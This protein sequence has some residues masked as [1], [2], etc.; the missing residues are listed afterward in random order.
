VF[1]HKLVHYFQVSFELLSIKLVTMPHGD[2]DMLVFLYETLK[3]HRWTKQHNWVTGEPLSKWD[4]VTMNV[5][6]RIMKLDLEGGRL[7]GVLE[8]SDRWNS[9]VHVETLVLQSNLLRGPIPRSMAYLS[10][11]QV[12]NLSWN[13]LSGPIPEEIYEHCVSLRVLRLDSNKLNGELSPGIANLK[14]LE[15]LNLSHNLLV[16]LIPVCL[17]D[18]MKLE[19]QPAQDLIN[20]QLSEGTLDSGDDIPAQGA[21]EGGRDVER[22]YDDD[23]LLQHGR[24]GLEEALR[25]EEGEEGEGERDWEEVRGGT[26]GGP[27]MPGTQSQHQSRSASP[28]KGAH[29]YGRGDGGA[30]S[31][32][33][34]HS[35]SGHGV[36]LG[37]G[38][39]NK[40]RDLCVCDTLSDDEMEHVE[41]GESD[42][43]GSYSGSESGSEY[44]SSGEEEEQGDAFMTNIVPVDRL[45]VHSAE[46]PAS[47]QSRGQEGGD[48]GQSPFAP[49]ASHHHSHYANIL[50]YLRVVDLKYNKFSC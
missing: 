47:H 44:S 18:H 36:L 7:D 42:S 1:Y 24:M 43:S 28:A 26:A 14:L 50:T 33:S 13:R 22:L 35:S 6:G 25:G 39:S 30:G 11:I 31:G 15:H 19:D 41:E 3:G 21:G 48:F 37:S 45:F 9:L 46:G 2:F 20:Y 38:R 49:V 4:G 40:T 10:A 32:Y 29:G 5:C 17:I 34:H 8:E 27:G 12:L 23:Y 16:G